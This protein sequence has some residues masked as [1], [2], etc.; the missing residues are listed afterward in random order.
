M[1][2]KKQKHY[3]IYQI[4]NLVNGKIYIGKHETTNIEDDYFGSGK[5][6]LNAINK[7]GLENFE[8]KILIDLKNKEEMNLLE[9]MVVTEEFCKRDDVYNIKVGGDGGWDYVNQ[10][11]G[12]QQ[13]LK[14]KRA[15]QLGGNTTTKLLKSHNTSPTKIFLARSTEEQIEKWRL[16]RLAA[17]KQWDMQHPGYFAGARN[18]MYGCTH[19]NEIRKKISIGQSGSRNSQYGKMWICNDLT[20]ESVKIMKTDPI[21]EGWRKGRICKK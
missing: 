3:L 14:K 11:S 18:P 21:P 8:F 6:L 19:S 2:E 7:H 10:K 15:S 1:K 17:K 5:Y 13:S 16:H 4:T 9:K 20:K 12:Y